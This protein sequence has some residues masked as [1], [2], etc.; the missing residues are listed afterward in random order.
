MNPFQSMPEVNSPDFIPYF[1]SQDRFSR[2]LGYKA[3][4][5]SP[6]KS[7]YEIEVDETFHNPVY[8]VHGAALFAA[9][10]S[11]AGAAMAGWIKSSGKKCKFMATGTAEIKYRK[12]VTSGKIRIYSEITEQKRATV[13]LISRSIDQEGDLVAELL[14]IWVVK[15][16]NE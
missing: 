9:M 13:R 2:K 3:L 1:Q 12:S 8:I 16:E 5:A 11:S 14:S 15:F 10:D 7:E 6:G 4:Q